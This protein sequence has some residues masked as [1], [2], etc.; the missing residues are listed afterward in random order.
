MVA[1]ALS[2]LL[3]AGCATVST[4]DFAALQG[5]VAR[6]QARQRELT[7][8]VE[9]LGRSVEGSRGPQ[10]NMVAD[11]DS[12]RQE[13]ARLQGRLEEE[14][15]PRGGGDMADL[16]RRLARV[17]TFLGLAGGAEPVA[18]ARPPVAAP[19]PAP[20]PAPM[21][22]LDDDRPP[23][24]GKAPAPAPAAAEPAPQSADAL[25]SLGQRLHKQRSFQASRDRL[26]DFLKRYPK[27]RRSDEAQF[28]IGDGLYAEKK[29]EEAILSFNQLVKRFP[30][31]NH[32]PA[33][34][35][36]EGMSF[37]E[38]G[39]KRTAKI[40]LGKLVK[41]YPKSAEAKQAEKLMA[42]MP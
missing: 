10:A 37:S 9:L 3:A 16:E 20:R 6:E 26:E 13:I 42:K 19:A 21:A 7:K 23:K 11:M 1:L 8:R 40:V 12:L 36:K 31:S 24:P 27:D 18:G 35:L 4:E 22:D 15:A 5:T 41:S 29:Y 33:A 2:S 14:S 39:D 38:L 30:D 32:A 34:L 17:E 25:F 28:L